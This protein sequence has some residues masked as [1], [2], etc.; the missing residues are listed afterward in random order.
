MDIGTPYR[1]L[2]PVDGIK[3]LQTFV[4]ALDEAEWTANTFRQEALA[5]GPHSVTQNI[6]LKHEWHPYANPW[7]MRRMED[8]I[9]QWAREKGMDPADLTPVDRF[10]TDMGFV[11]TFGQWEKFQ[12]VLAPVVASAIA[13]LRTENGVIMRLALVRLPAG[14]TI[15]S[16]TDK[17]P[18]A[19]VAHRLHVPLSGG[20]AVHYK[21]DGKKFFMKEGHVYDFNNRVK[22]SV[23]NKGKQDRVNLFIDYYPEPKPFVA[24]PLR[25]V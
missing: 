21:I 12:D 14:K 4:E 22:H 18:L 8:L 2:G 20:R 10:D 25:P 23:M 17:Q 6:I 9:I 19:G 7:R 16:H 11:Y 15:K 3:A 5:G 1:D 13:P 24:N